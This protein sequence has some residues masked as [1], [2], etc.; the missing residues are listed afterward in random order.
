L[1]VENL[2]KELIGKVISGQEIT[3]KDKDLWHKHGHYIISWL[4][5]HFEYDPVELPDYEIYE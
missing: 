3:E 1:S 2:A 4:R 5:R